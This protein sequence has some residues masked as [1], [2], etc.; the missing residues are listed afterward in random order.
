[1]DEA[2]DFFRKFLKT[3]HAARVAALSEPDEKKALAA[4]R[5]ADAAYAG[6]STA[7]IDRPDE[8]ADDERSR[9]QKTVERALFVVREYRGGELYQAIVGEPY[10]R[11]YGTAFSAALFVAE[12]AGRLN[13]VARYLAC[14]QCDA[15]G[16]S[17]RKIC[18]DCKGS[19]WSVRQTGKAIDFASLGRPT[20]TR[21]LEKP[22]V[23]RFQAAY[24]A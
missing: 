1:M 11:P 7:G 18:S 23:D 16:T 13:I 21:R 5:L 10:K 17:G 9:A 6:Q 19:G 22:D 8:V 4:I 15:T 12:E 24:D 14:A 3:E 20:A 2:V